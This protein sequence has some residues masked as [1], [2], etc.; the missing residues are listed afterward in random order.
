MNIWIDFSNS[1]HP[2]IFAP[3]IDRLAELGHHVS[4]TCRDTAQTSDLTLSRWP[5]AAVIGGTTPRTKRAK[6]AAIVQRVAALSGWALGRKVDLALSH[7]SYAQI[8]AARALGIRVVTVMDF[9]HQQAN[10]LAF[11]LAHRILLPEALPIEL[12]R[13]QGARSTKIARFAGLKEE[14]VFADFEPDERAVDELRHA[15]EAVLV[16][17]RAP[18]PRASYLRAEGSLFVDAL[19]VLCEQEHVRVILLARHDDQRAK[20]DALGHSNLIVPAGTADSR[21]LMYAADLVLGGGGTMTREAALLGVPT[22]SAYPGEPPAVD[23][24]LEAQGLLRRL[25]SAEELVE[26]RPRSSDPRAPHELRRRGRALAERVAEL[27][28]ASVRTS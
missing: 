8:A 25:V 27:V 1:P 20:I 28:L 17:A 9:E 12:V 24:W 16:V 2:L 23:G 4:I 10:H 26:L 19:R 14:L 22:V 5:D 3:I 11:R 13:R 6:A 21:S 15:H 7:N 18:N